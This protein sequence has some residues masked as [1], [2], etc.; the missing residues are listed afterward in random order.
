[1]DLHVVP[2][3]HGQPRADVDSVEAR[4]SAAPD[5][6]TQGEI[7]E[8]GARHGER[9]IDEQVAAPEADDPA[10]KIGIEAESPRQWAVVEATFEEQGEG[11]SAAAEATDRLAPFGRQPDGDIEQRLNAHAG[12][13]LAAAPADLR[14]QPRAERNPPVEIVD[15][16]RAGL[17]RAEL[18]AGRQ[19]PRSGESGLL[20]A[21]ERPGGQ[22]QA[23][24]LR[25]ERRERRGRL[26]GPAFADER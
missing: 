10:L 11:A 20:A 16:A 26:G 1:M 7:A 23:V 2:N 25:P 3:A 19:R 14:A 17:A 6:R 9:A 21:E 12:R 5:A 18:A 15:E 13:C 8:R 24:E 4:L 22:L